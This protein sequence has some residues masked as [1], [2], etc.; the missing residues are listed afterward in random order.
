M[1]DFHGAKLA[2]LYGDRIV[3]ILRDDTPSI[4]WPGQWDLPGGGREG[5]ETP[6]ACVLRELREELGLILSASDLH[7]R[8]ESHT[9][10]GQ[11]IWFFVSEQPDF[12]PETVCFGDEGQEWRLVDID[13]FLTH[14]KVIPRHGERLKSYLDIREDVT[15]RPTCSG[16]SNE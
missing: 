3:T 14:P 15:A 16:V 9:H 13:W 6:E 5:A 8:M 11:R 10:D 4:P 7:W 12:D 1:N 2:I